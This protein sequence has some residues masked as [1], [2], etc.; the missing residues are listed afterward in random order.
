MSDEG[1]EIHGIEAQNISIPVVPDL[2]MQSFVAN[3]DKATKKFTVDVIVRSSF[4]KEIGGGFG[5]LNGEF[6]AFHIRMKLDKGIPIP[7]PEP[8]VLQWK[9]FD[10][11][12]TNIAKGPFTLDGTVFLQNSDEWKTIPAYTWLK[13]KVGDAVKVTLFEIDGTGHLA[14]PNELGIGGNIRVFGLFDAQKLWA[15]QGKVNLLG[16]VSYANTSMTATGE[17]D[18]VNFGGSQYLAVG[19]GSLGITV[20]PQFNVA[21][22]LKADLYVPDL[23]KN[24][25][26]F[27]ALNKALGLPYKLYSEQM[28]QNNLSLAFNWDTKGIGMGVLGVL[29]DLSQNPVTNPLKFIHIQNTP[30]KLGTAYRKWDNDHTASVDTT[31]HTM[32]TTAGMQSLVVQIWGNPTAPASVMINPAGTLY[33]ATAPDSSVIYYPPTGGDPSALWIVKSPAAGTWKLGTI[34]EKAGDSVSVWGIPAKRSD[35]QFSSQE[36]GRTIQAQW[37]GAGAPTGSTVSFYLDTDNRDYD[38]IFIGS[39]DESTG[40]FSYTMTDSLPDCGY[41]IYAMRNDSLSIS[42]IY[43]PTYF[44]NPKSWLMAPTG[45][46]A[47]ATPAGEATITWNPSADPN[48]L[49]YQIRVTDKNGV[50]SIYTSTGFNYTMA[51]L[52]IDD[53]QTKRVSIQTIGDNNL[54]G[55]WSDPVAIAMLGVD[56]QAVTGAAPQQL[57]TF[58]APNPSGDRATLFVNLSRQARLQ[59]ELYD[60]AG[61]HI[62]TVAQ[63]TFEAGTFRHEVDVTG[64]PNGSYVIRI[65]GDGLE[66]TQMLVVRR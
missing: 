1:W 4:F 39:A 48:A 10:V 22:S 47:V 25:P 40:A 51:Q 59:V 62:A 60:A 38:G 14:W 43:S 12:A 35:F 57:E 42:S 23:F 49:M 64:L 65:T 11:L 46:Q 33:A 55:C 53:W 36:Q 56:H 44:A 30:V 8:P 28:A 54:S 20:F 17:L 18:F 37:S 16:R 6:D 7:I 9:G 13:D 41:Y 5:L 32:T 66:G 58:V 45:I 61:R 21:T 26:I 52:H 15:I 63:G 27:S 19:T 3:Y 29:V 2:C 31:F 24:N 34:G 50:D